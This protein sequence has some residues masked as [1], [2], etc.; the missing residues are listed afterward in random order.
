[1]AVAAVKEK[2]AA[3]LQELTKTDG[4]IR[5]EEIVG[6]VEAV[7]DSIEGDMTAIGLKVYADIE[8]LARYINTARAEI[9]ELCPDDINSEH[10]PAA[11]DE[12]TAIV[13][14]TEQA[15]HTIFEAVEGIEALTEKMDPEVAEKVSAAVTSVFEA[16]G[17]QDITG[18]RIT[19][20]VTALQKVEV[21][22]DALLNAFGDDLKR[23]GAPRAPEKKTKTPSGAPARP[24]EDLLNG[25]QLPENA[26]SQDDID[27]LFG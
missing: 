6:V 18:Q 22:V 16:C 5:P 10:L 25:P 17:F 21:K 23:E 19:K 12:L 7:I 9:A 11:T 24:D 27:A 8:A 3:Q 13:G 15:T 26:I 20:V 14:A 4:S 2:I 1:M